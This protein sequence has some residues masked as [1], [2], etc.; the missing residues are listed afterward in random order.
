MRI[1]VPVTMTLKCKDTIMAAR[2]KPMLGTTC[3]FTC[4]IVAAFCGS[5]FADSS[6][7]FVD[8]DGDGINDLYTDG[9]NNGI[10]DTFESADESAQKDI[11]AALGDVFNTGDIAAGPSDEILSAYDGFCERKFRTRDLCRHRG[12]FN[13]GE[14]FGPGNGIGLGALTSGCVGGVCQ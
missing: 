13:A 2:T 1:S 5:M 11:P 3:L 7:L 14:N 12:G 8:H 9:N 4:I 6:P 10:P